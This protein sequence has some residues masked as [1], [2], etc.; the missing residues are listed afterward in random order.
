MELVEALDAALKRRYALGP[1]SLGREPRTPITEPKGLEIRMRRIMDK[2]KGNRREAAKAAG[3]PYSTWN[4]ALKGRNV[5]K[6]TL[7]KI[8][9][10]FGKLVTAPAR[11]LRVKRVG[12]PDNWPIR[13]VVVAD[14]GPDP[15]RHKSHGGRGA[16]YV[17]GHGTGL[18][19]AEAASLSGTD[20]PGYRVFRA[21]GL[22]SA[23]IVDAWLTQGAEAAADVL[24]QEIEGA[25]GEGFAF[26]GDD[27]EVQI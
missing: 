26:E 6:K 7:D 2:F 5:T 8:L 16:R 21:E 3:V 1:H 19:K 24:L 15:R 4:H 11:A 20:D 23:R 22:D 17:N 10:A 14:P 27:V 12:Y 18:T 9:G 13:A 25:Y